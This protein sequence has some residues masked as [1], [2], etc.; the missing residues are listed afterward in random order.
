MHVSTSRLWLKLWCRSV[1]KVWDIIIGIPWVALWCIVSYPQ[2]VNTRQEDKDSNDKD[3]HSSVWVLKERKHLRQFRSNQNTH[4]FFCCEIVLT[5]T[6]KYP[7]RRR[8]PMMINRDPIKK[9]TVA[10]AMALYGTLGGLLLNCK[11]GNMLYLI[12]HRRLLIAV[13]VFAKYWTGQTYLVW[14]KMSCICD[15]SVDDFHQRQMNLWAVKLFCCI[16]YLDM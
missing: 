8:A 5:V 1:I 13:P 12:K 14:L 7:A 4:S 16:M 15:S 6:P 11:R 3:R 9:S 10:S 2:V